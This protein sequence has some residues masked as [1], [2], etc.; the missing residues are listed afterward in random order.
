MDK[1]ISELIEW[2]KV[3]SAYE[4]PSY[5]ELPSIPLYMEQVTGYVNDI[6]KP[7]NPIQK[8]LLTSFMVNNYVKAG[9]IA[10][11]EKKKYS[12]DHLGY[13]LAITTLKRTLSISEISLLIEMDKDVTMDKSVL[14]GFFRVM[15]KDV[16]QE[17]AQKTLIK[18]VSF[19]ERYDKETSQK[20]PEAENH[21][22]DSLALIALRMS[23]Q[24]AVYQALSQNILDSV[25]KDL[26]GVKAYQLENT[27]SN[28]EKEREMEINASQS[29][30]VAL[31][32]KTLKK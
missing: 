4:L 15:E 12:Q 5:K 14:Y 32:K 11:P 27:P 16:L 26:H 3:A 1:E 10:A 23:I 7:L 21:L 19:K 24:A 28:K 31:I 18:A 9:I 6:L 29:K 2:L 13:L 17:T 25:G 20:D 8:D 22:R 30:R